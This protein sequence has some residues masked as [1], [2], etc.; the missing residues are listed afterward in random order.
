M[1]ANDETVVDT[2]AVAVMD[3]IKDVK[4]TLTAI[5]PENP[6]IRNILLSNLMDVNLATV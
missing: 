5:P 4:S 3:E 1:N 6:I 2:I